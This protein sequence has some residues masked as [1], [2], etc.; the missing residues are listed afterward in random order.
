MSSLDKALSVLDSLTEQELVSFHKEVCRR[1]ARVYEPRYRA[2]RDQNFN[3]AMAQ[4]DT[5]FVKGLSVLDNHQE[6]PL[7]RREVNQ[8]AYSRSVPPVRVAVRQRESQLE[9]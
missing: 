8:S 1:A 4:R 2:I 7:T 6:K 9:A 3:A 5:R